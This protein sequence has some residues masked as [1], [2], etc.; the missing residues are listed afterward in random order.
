M[1]LTVDIEPDVLQAARELAASRKVAL[2]ALLSALIRRGLQSRAMRAVEIR[3]GVPVL[4]RR[5][6]GARKP[7]MARVNK[8]RDDA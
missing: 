1:R 8:F 4:P 6:R 5:A 3:N 2:G 7:T